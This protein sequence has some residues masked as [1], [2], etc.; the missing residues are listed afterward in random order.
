MLN[1]V[2][3]TMIAIALVLVALTVAALAQRC[4]IVTCTTIGNITTCTCI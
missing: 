4:Q 2:A 1:T 3:I